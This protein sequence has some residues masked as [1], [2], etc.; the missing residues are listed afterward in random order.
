MRYAWILEAGSGYQPN[1]HCYRRRAD[2]KA[3]AR[4]MDGCGLSAGMR[5][6]R[7]TVTAEQFATFR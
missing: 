2:A 5:P 6:R 1:G 4:D 7:V 3:A